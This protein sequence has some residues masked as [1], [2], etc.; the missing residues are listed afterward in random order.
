[1][2]CMFSVSHSLFY[3]PRIMPKALFDIL[4]DGYANEDEDFHPTHSNEHL[5]YQSIK[6]HLTRLLNARR[7]SIQHMP[8]YGLPDVSAIYQDLPYSIDQL[9]KAVSET[10][11]KYEPRLEKVIVTHKPDKE[12]DCV[13]YL[14]IQA[15]LTNSGN[16]K[17]DTYFMSSGQTVISS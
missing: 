8:D 10:I 5:L 6:T 13:L 9:L 16:I 14:Q 4:T 17:F 11:E 3:E 1:M 12:Q 15:Q 7:G 2:G